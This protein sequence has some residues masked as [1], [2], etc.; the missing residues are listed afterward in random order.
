MR[1]V[2]LEID[3]ND[4]DIPAKLGQCYFKIKKYDEAK[5]YLLIASKAL[6]LNVYKSLGHIYKKQNKP[7]SST[8]YFHKALEILSPD[9]NS[10]FSIYVDIAENHYALNKYIHTVE[11]YKKALKLEL[12][13]IWILHSRNKVFVDIAAVYADKL[14]DEENAIKYLKEIKKDIYINDDRYY[15]YAQ[16]QIRLLNEQ[17]FMEGK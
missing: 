7:D 16:Q 11:W 13:D 17:L 1:V 3:R 8:F 14:N 2:T 15:E 9:Y 6:D 4:D 10:I 5:Y 12:R